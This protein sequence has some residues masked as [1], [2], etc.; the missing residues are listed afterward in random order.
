MNIIILDTETT[1]LEEEARLVQLAYKNLSTGD[2][3]DE[4]FKPPVP[5][6][7]GAM[8]VHHI[9]EEMVAENPAFEGSPQQAALIEA[10][11]DSVLVAHNAPFDINILNNE[12]V[13]V[14][15]YIDTLKVSMHLLDSE[16]YSMQ[17]LRYSLKLNVDA[18]AHDASGDIAVL[19]VLFDYLKAKVKEKFSLESDD[20]IF[21][22]MIDLTQEPVLL[23]VFWFGKHFG[24]T[25]E[26]VVEMDR[27]YLEWL[28]GEETKKD[29]E[30]QNEDLV[31]TLKRTLRIL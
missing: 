20:E 29:D 31:H 10:L 5:I 11:K 19:E 22:K 12:G 13:E 15:K 8:A 4:Y 6:S 3:V 26:E 30:D 1:G 17:Y 27:G 25:F 23:K 7:Y 28:H 9:T 2:E 18:K 16:Q 21:Q 24:K 14:E